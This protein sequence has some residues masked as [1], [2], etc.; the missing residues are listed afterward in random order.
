MIA[1][2]YINDIEIITK[3][4]SVAAYIEANFAFLQ[5]VQ[6]EMILNRSKKIKNRDSF[7][8]AKSSLIEIYD[9]V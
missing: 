9:E 7:E 5:N 2:T 1:K 6:R 3:E 4:L 8:L